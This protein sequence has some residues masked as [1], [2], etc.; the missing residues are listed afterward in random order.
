MY[1]RYFVLFAML[2]TGWFLRK[3]N[4]ID[5]KMNH[6]INKLVVYFA[7]P[8]MIVHNIGTLEMNRTVITQFLISFVL[9]LV[10]FYL[11]GLVS[12]LWAK[13][14]K[15]P[16]EISNVAEFAMAMPNDGFMGFP[17]ALIFFGETGL[18]LMLAHNAAMNIFTFTHGIRLMRRNNKGQRK[19]TPNLLMRAVLKFLVNPNI[20]ALVIGFAVSLLGTGLPQAVDEYLLYIGGVSTPMAMIFIGSNL[21]NYNFLET[22]RDLRVL[23]CSV[24]KLLVMP[25]LTL[26]IVYFLP[27]AGI[28]KCCVVLGIAFPTAAT[29]SMLAEQEGQ[30]VGMASR[31]LFISTIASIVTVPLTIKFLTFMFL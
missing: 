3:I 12:W 21:T 17:V 26:A 11:Y 25:A 24:M 20:L 19:M 22:A 1:A 29:V 4:F 16:R 9:S 15:Y 18:L 8:C 7:Y 14:R 10:C 6:S 5:D 30:S 2:F 13:A 27:I 31:V 28:I 23:E